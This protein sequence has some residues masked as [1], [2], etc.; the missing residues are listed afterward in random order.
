MDFPL[1]WAVLQQP[2][3]D[4]MDEVIHKASDL[5]QVM[6]AGALVQAT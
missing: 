3:T 5:T 2:V 1:N 4:D 6:K